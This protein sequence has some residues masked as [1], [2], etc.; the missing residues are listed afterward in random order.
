MHP[1]IHAGGRRAAFEAVAA[2][3]G[4]AEAGGEALAC[5][6]RAT[7]RGLRRAMPIR[8][9]GDGCLAAPCG[10]SQRRRTP[11]PR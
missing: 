1:A 5:T 2:E 7:V 8:G 4:A 6:I 10:G 11:A 3:H 9:K